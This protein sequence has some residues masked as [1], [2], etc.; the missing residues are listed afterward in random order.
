MVCIRFV[1]VV[2]F[3]DATVDVVISTLEL[4]TRMLA[5]F[6]GWMVTAAIRANEMVRR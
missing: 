1:M 6:R 4:Y 5:D 2:S 3:T